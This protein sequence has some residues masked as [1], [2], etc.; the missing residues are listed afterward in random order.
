MDAGERGALTATTSNAYT[1][2]PVNRSAV[3]RGN[4]GELIDVRVLRYQRDLP[5]TD[6]TDMPLLDPEIGRRLFAPIALDLVFDSLSL[7]E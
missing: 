2:A 3:A 7:V 5:G 1:R 4:R 6:N